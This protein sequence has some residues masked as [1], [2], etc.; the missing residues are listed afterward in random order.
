MPARAGRCAHICIYLADGNLRSL[1]LTGIDTDP[2]NAEEVNTIVKLVEMFYHDKEFCI[3]T[4]YDAQR[5]AL[6]DALKRAKLPSE[7]TE[8]A[9]SFVYNVDSFQGAPSSYFYVSV[10]THP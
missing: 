7:F 4:P 6:T 1:W 10:P 8:K 5:S 3:I 9:E 2:Q